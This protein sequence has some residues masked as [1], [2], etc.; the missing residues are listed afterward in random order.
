MMSLPNEIMAE[1]SALQW[2]NVPQIKERFAALLTD[3]QKC[4]RIEVL[5]PLVI[6]RLQE[7]FYKAKLPEE[8]Q[9]VISKSVEGSK[10]IHSPSD[11]LGKN[12]RNIVR[13]YKGVNYEVK[14][15]H[16]GRCEYNGK[17][18]KSMT[19]AAKVIT[20]THTNGPAFFGVKV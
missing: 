1:I 13:N 17:V 20:G 10:L 4:D 18:Y 8:V 16:D 15:Y 11:A 3:A 7:R 5:R 9:R 19:A 12:V 14:L 6:Y 2:L